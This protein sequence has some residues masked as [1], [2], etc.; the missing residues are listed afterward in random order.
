MTRSIVSMKAVRG[1]C[2]LSALALV[3]G[4]S[5][6]GSN[7]GFGGA[8]SAGAAH[9]AGAG[10]AP[11]V[12]AGSS[13]APQSQG[14]S[15]N[16]AGAAT[17]AGGA[18][19]GSAFARAGAPGQGGSGGSAGALGSAAGA[20]GTGGGATGAAGAATGAAGAAGAAGAGSFAP[21]PA[22]DPCKILPLGDS[23][24]WGINYGGGYRIK[25][26][27]HTSADNKKITFVGYDA[28]NPPTAAA[29]SALGSASSMWVAKHEGHSGWTI[30]QDD[31]L[32]TGKS[33]ANN[34][35]VNY[36][37]KKVVADFT[38]HIVLIHL[39]TNDMYQTPAG[40]PDRL[41][42]LIDHVVTD[43]PN[44]LVVVSSIIP[45]P[46]GASAVTTFN[47]AVPGVVQA[48]ASAG[49]HVIYVDMFA[50]LTT[51]D[52]GSDQIHPNEGGYE[53]MAVVWYNAIK[54]YLH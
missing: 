29:L 38:P 46:S 7:D 30:Q 25:L 27:T 1:V 35:G 15:S 31:D 23:I 3:F 22:T 2:A 13:G 12:S 19:A 8:P 9:S 42:T 20:A 37:G 24:T 44:A 40:A 52:L 26:F 33:T 18:A 45:F 34:D 21:C 50:A 51:S 36:T 11:V 41:G 49:K 6:D 4:C 53:K 43:A 17:G 54:T 32:V 16:T 10:G 48:R 47:K 5:S 14:G 28:G 39:G